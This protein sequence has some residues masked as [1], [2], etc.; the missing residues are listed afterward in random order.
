MTMK[1]SNLFF[2]SPDDGATGGAPAPASTPSSEPAATSQPTQPA[3]QA[4]QVESLLEIKESAPE[5]TGEQ[6]TQ[7]TAQPSPDAIAAEEFAKSIVVN[8]ADGKPMEI[9]ADAIKTLSPLFLKHKMTKESARELV[10][11]YAAYASQVQIKEQQAHLEQ[12]KAIRDETAKAFGPDLATMTKQA[13]KGGAHIFG[14]YWNV[15][16]KVPEFCNNAAVIRGLAEVGRGISNDN[17]AGGD[18]CGNADTG[19]FNAD[20]WISGSNRGQGM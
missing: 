20:R 18:G 13:A 5:Q 8:G 1:R 4:Q 11:A 10:G 2:F 17:G 15:L 16:S 14:E 6:K 9:D 19:E 7:E 12:M 3:P